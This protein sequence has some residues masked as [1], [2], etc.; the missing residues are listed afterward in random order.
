M[1]FEVP[2]LAE[3]QKS[4]FLVADN[5]SDAAVNAWIG[6]RKG[7]AMYTVS[8]R[9][10]FVG[11]DLPFVEKLAAQLGLN[12]HRAVEVKIDGRVCIACG[13]PGEAFRTAQHLALT[14]RQAKW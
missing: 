5:V 9:V 10:V 14:R 12:P 7:A 4:G 1:M 8:H 2:E 13:D 6:Q 3:A 11:L